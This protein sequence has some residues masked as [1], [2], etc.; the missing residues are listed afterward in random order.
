MSISLIIKGDRKIAKAAANKR[1]I[2]ID[3][4]RV[5]AR[6]ATSET[7][8]LARNDDRPKVASWFGEITKA[9][10]PLGTLLLFTDLD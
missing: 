8:A 9:P 7:I 5:T 4:V 10:F 1:G 2:Y 3:V 6:Y